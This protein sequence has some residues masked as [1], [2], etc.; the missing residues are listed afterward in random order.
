VPDERWR[1]LKAQAV[2]SYTAASPLVARLVK[3]EFG[4]RFECEFPTA[5]ACF[6]DDYRARRVRAY[7]SIAKR[8]SSSVR[9]PI[10]SRICERNGAPVS[11][12]CGQPYPMRPSAVSSL[13][14]R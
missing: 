7:R 6:L 4:K 1:E 12:T 14:Q 9:P 5:T 13:P 3:D 11:R 8:S 2:A 10:A